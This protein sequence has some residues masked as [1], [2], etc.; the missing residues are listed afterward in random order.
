MIDGGGGAR[1][2]I[3]TRDTESNS[4]LLLSVRRCLCICAHAV[5]TPLCFF[6]ASISSHFFPDR[7]I[8]LLSYL[9][10]LLLSITAAQHST[11]R[12]N[13]EVTQTFCLPGVP[14]PGRTHPALSLLTESTWFCRVRY[15][16]P[17]TVVASRLSDSSS[18]V[19]CSC[20]RSRN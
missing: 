4:S 16:T 3:Q 9:T 12:L 17:L 13:R 5:F 20:S 10:C 6:F 8:F 11:P 19:H 15:L 18:F 7:V 2:E 14:V 1:E